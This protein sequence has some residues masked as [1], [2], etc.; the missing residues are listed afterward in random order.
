MIIIASICSILGFSNNCKLFAD[1]HLYLR[2]FK[3]ILFL[4][5]DPASFSANFSGSELIPPV[6]PVLLIFKELLFNTK[7]SLPFRKFF[8]VVCFWV[9]GIGFLSIKFWVFTFLF[10]IFL[11][12]SPKFVPFSLSIFCN[13]SI[14]WVWK[15]LYTPPIQYPFLM[16][17]SLNNNTDLLLY[18]S[19]MYNG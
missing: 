13:L 12:S 19:F 8:P 11:N 10:A 6:H 2:V 18:K 3:F 15:L 9:G 7:N 16:I 1:P 14:F 17:Y 4:T 5:L